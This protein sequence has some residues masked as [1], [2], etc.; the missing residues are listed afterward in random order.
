MKAILEFQLPEDDAEYRSAANARDAWSAI[1]DVRRHIR[2]QLK[3]AVE[4]SDETRKAL[5]EIR[6]LLPHEID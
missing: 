6:E 5:E 3:Y 1:D 4:L 2:A